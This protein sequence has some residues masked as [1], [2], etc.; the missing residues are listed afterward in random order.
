MSARQASKGAERHG[1]LNGLKVIELAHVMAGPTCGRLLADLGADVIKVE[2]PGGED[3]RHM[4]PPW[5]GGDSAAYVMMNRNKRNIAIDLKQP[6]GRRAFLDIA[7]DCDVV[8][9][10]FRKGTLERL[11]LG[12]DVLEQ[13][14]PR[15][16]LCSISGYGRSGPLADDGGFDLMAQAMSGLMSFT[17]ESADRPPVKVGAP[18]ADI[19]AGMLATIGV[20]AALQERERSGRG[21]QIDTSLYEAG[22]FYTLWQSAIYLAGGGVPRPIGS[23]HPLD[24]PY[25]AFA[26]SDGWIVVGAANQANWLR[27]IAA[28]DAPE[29]GAD[30]RFADNPSRMA[31]LA[32][33]V[34]V[35][36]EIFA[37]KPSAVWLE[38]L[39]QHNVP[40][41]PI[42]AMDAVAHH[43]QALAREMFVPIDHHQCGSQQ[44]VGLPI[45]FSRTPGRVAGSRCSRL[46]QD[47]AEILREAGWPESDIAAAFASRAIPQ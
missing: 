3:S 18:V 19:G 43:P 4:A 31:N 36:G 6:D 30:P 47:A 34:A 7:R 15:L 25:Q 27:L 35:L 37:A 39:A 24:A 21:Q 32:T 1:P 44:T 38:I 8:I 2:R 5:I 23:A 29:L 17:G 10:N 11:G 9:E 20:L 28:V 42:L 22:I 46:G 12:F 45:K 26:T 14:N 13:R 40:V 41:A 16:I 33:L